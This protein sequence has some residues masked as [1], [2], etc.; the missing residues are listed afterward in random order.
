MNIVMTSC[1]KFIEIQG[2]A[3]GEPFS[4]RKMDELL[5][6]AYTGIK[7]ITAAQKKSLGTL[8]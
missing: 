1:G 6:L 7:R 8:Q 2:T 5:D 4:R 3:E